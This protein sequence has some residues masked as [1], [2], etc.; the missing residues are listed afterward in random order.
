MMPVRVRFAPSP[1][2]P[3]HIGGVRTALYNYL[4]ARKHG[5]QFILRIEDTDQTR[6]VP[7][8]EAYIIESLRWL[9]LIPDEGVSFSGDRGPYRQSDRKAIYQEHAHRLWA[10]GMAYIAFDRPE[11]LEARRTAEEN[12]T[13]NHMTRVGLDNSLLLPASAVRERMEAGEPYVIRLLVEPDRQVLVRD[14]IRGDVVFNSSE[15]DDKVLLKADGMPTYHLANIV[16]DHLMGITHVIRGEEWLPSTAHHVLLYEASGWLDT[17]PAFAHLPLIL[18]PVGN[19]KLSKRDGAKFGMPVFP[20]SWEADGEEGFVGF[21]ETG[22]LPEAVLN[23]VALLGWH[24]SDDAELF[25]L[26]ELVERF[27]IG[28]ISKG[29]A[30]FDYDKAKW[31]NQQYIQRT[32]DRT[33]ADLIAPM[34]RAK[35]YTDDLAY[36]ARVAGLMKE[37]VTFLA[38]FVE[39]G[40]YFFEPVRAFDAEQVSKRWRPQSKQM[41]IDLIGRLSEEQEFTAH[42]LDASVKSFMSERAVKAGELLPLLRI[43]LAGTMQGPAVFDMMEVLGRDETLLRLDRAV[44]VFEGREALGNLDIF[45]NPIGEIEKGF[46]LDAVNKFLDKNLEDKKINTE[47]DLP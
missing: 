32:D 36:C 33:L 28:Q 2:G 34:A 21:R 45:V 24:P 16:D 15:L 42:A 40:Y 46:D 27:T 47:K 44:A 35:G 41:W 6:Y 25:S 43:A 19:G 4:F 37:R 18:K 1:T 26:D 30:R 10:S 20:L 39:T 29:G 3:L 7:G 23:F 31:F 22:F 14:L 17:M 38:D 12:F 8:A 11:V 5:G 9:H 13:Y